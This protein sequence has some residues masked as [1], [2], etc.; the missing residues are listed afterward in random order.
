MSVS[1]KVLLLMDTTTV[2]ELTLLQDWQKLMSVKLRTPG[3]LTLY[4][5]KQLSSTLGPY[6]LALKILTSTTSPRDG[7]PQLTLRVE[8]SNPTSAQA[9]SATWSANSRPVTYS[10]IT[11]STLPLRQS[12]IPWPFALAVRESTSTSR[13]TQRPSE[14]YAW[15]RT[16]FLQ[17]SSL[18]LTLYPLLKSPSVPE[19]QLWP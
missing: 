12:A 9:L 17:L 7:V 13:H 15:Q 6:P 8:R 10:K 3:E 16:K 19:P 5:L 1:G 4:I 11:T 14:H 18:L 2:M